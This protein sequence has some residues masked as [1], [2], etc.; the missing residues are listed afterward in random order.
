MKIRLIIEDKKN[1][2]DPRPTT[3]GS[4]ND[5]IT[6]F[7][8]KEL[9]SDLLFLSCKIGSKYQIKPTTKGMKVDTINALAVREQKRTEK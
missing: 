4:H 3:Q 2:K 9:S 6:V 1:V 7:T 5:V 8:R